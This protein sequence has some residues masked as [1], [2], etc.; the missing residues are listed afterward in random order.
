MI[1]H[2]IITENDNWIFGKTYHSNTYFGEWCK[3]KGAVN[4]P[5]SEQLKEIERKRIKIAEEYRKNNPR[6]PSKEYFEACKRWPNKG[7]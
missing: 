2:D 7:N 5:T 6:E 1:R 3:Y 4:P